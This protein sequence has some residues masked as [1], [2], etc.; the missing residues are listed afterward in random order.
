MVLEM[1]YKFKKIYNPQCDLM[2][3][4]MIVENQ[5]GIKTRQH[6]A[7]FQERNSNQSYF[8]GWESGGGGGGGGGGGESQDFMQ[9]ALEKLELQTILKEKENQTIIVCSFKNFRATNSNPAGI[10]LLKVNNRN[11]ETRCEIC[12]KLIIKTPDY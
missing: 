10:Y 1:R 6:P 12:L 11:T 2:N 5:G 7:K 8:R 4:F 9:N 3:I